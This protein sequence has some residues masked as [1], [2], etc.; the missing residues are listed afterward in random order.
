MKSEAI[1]TWLESQAEVLSVACD[2][3]VADDLR[4][5][6][7][8]FG[9]RPKSN[10]S[11]VFS[12]L[13]KMDTSDLSGSQRMD[14]F[15]KVV[16]AMNQAVTGIAKAGEAKDLKKLVDFVSAHR[17]LT[18][19]GFVER[20]VETLKSPPA[21]KPTRKAPAPDLSDADIRCYVA[22]LE[23]ALGDDR[24][25]D[26]VYSELSKDKRLRAADAKKIAKAFSGKA[27]SS[28]ADSLGRIFGRHSALMSARPKAEAIGGRL[29]S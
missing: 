21:K 3:S 10:A 11:V 24:G 14:K 1:R 7:K 29:A 13:E 22:R 26:E 8:I 23:T 16:A 6:A 9:V 25:F 19:D 12:A 20:A 2:S 27:G 5:F 17:R 18:L 4:A 15:A 28:K